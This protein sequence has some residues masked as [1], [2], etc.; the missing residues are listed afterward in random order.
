MEEEQLPIPYDINEHIQK[1]LNNM[2]L[3][4]SYI[5]KYTRQYIDEAAT[6]DKPLLEV[7]PG[8]GYVV[9]KVLKKGAEVIAIDLDARHLQIMHNEIPKHLHK[10][11]KLIK[12]RFPEAIH[13]KNNYLGGCYL[14]RVLGYL[15]PE[16][17]QFWLET[18][19]RYLAPGAKLYILATTPYRVSVQR[20]I[21]IYESRLN[22][23]SNLW[24]GYFVGL[25]A[26]IDSRFINFIPDMMIFFDPE[27]LKRELSRVGFDVLTC[28]M[29]ARRDLP[30]HMQY[31]GRE[32]IVAIAQKP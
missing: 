31:D 14:G 16:E 20:I 4:T 11:L 21:P 18:V 5:D 29:Y 6:I 32:G 10:N 8:Y 23:E 22:D 15:T 27:V 25:Q 3:V 13:L 24:P 28:N 17:L 2:G 12:G 26:L 7:G 19:F 9:R 30:Q 1:T